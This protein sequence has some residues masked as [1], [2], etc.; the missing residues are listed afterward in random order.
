MPGDFIPAHG[1]QLRELA[2]ESRRHRWLI[3]V[4]VLIPS[5]RPVL[6]SRRFAMRSEPAK[7]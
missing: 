5:R 1:G 2:S 6:W 7:F 4:P 3:S